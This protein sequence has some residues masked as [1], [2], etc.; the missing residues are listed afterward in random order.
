MT[1]AMTI[2]RDAAFRAAARRA[3]TAAVDEVRALFPDYEDCLRKMMAG[4]VPLDMRPTRRP[5]SHT[6]VVIVS[7]VRFPHR[8]YASDKLQVPMRRIDQWVMGDDPA[9]AEA[10]VAAWQE[11]ERQAAIDSRPKPYILAPA[12]KILVEKGHSLREIEGI[13]GISWITAKRARQ[14]AETGTYQ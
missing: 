14:V 13:L 7:G 12:V 4:S 3:F 9:G 8:R 10:A 11:R 5:P 6:G 2:D 1:K